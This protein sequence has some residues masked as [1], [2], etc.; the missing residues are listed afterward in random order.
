MAK[1]HSVACLVGMILRTSEHYLS[2]FYRLF[3][4]STMTSE[5]L[6]QFV[7]NKGQKLS[8]F[9]LSENTLSE[10]FWVRN[11][12]EVNV[13]SSRFTK[14]PTMLQTNVTIYKTTPMHK[15]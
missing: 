14:Y 7:R 4:V 2:Q 11:F 3:Y 9:I 13:F 8:E 5:I 10:K 1:I 6:K 15:P 12:F